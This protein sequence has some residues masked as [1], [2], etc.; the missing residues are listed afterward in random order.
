M[1]ELLKDKVCLITGASKGIGR[2][3]AEAFAEQG[4]IVYANARTQNSIDDWAKELS[5]KHQTKVVPVYFDV[6][7][8]ASAKKAVMQIKQN[9]NKVDVLVNNAGMVTYEMIPMAQMDTFKSML[10]VNVTGAFNLLQIVSRIM[11]RQKSGSIINMTSI[12]ADKGAK[13]Q[14]AYATTKGA[15][16]AMTKSAAKELASLQI[17]VNA[18]APGMVS[19]ERFL[20]VFESKFKDK[21]NNIGMGRLAS[22]NEIAD[23]CVFLSSDM[24]TYI[25]GQIIGIDGSTEL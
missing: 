5:E 15:I 23:L 14:V 11:S 18:V 13:G 9:E 2:S 16:I 24:S 25:T 1:K 22:P 6:T 10:D 21:I 17:R 4:A 8:L 12:V 3:I 7:D 20:N 19:T